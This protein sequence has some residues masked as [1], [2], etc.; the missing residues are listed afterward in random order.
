[1]GSYASQLD[2]K[3][4]WMVIAYIKSKQGKTQSTVAPAADSTA[5]K[6]MAAK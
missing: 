4:R 5:V 2:A 3:Q 6:A 1:M